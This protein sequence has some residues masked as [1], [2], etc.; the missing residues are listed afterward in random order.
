MCYKL[1]LCNVMGNS[2]FLYTDRPLHSSSTNYKPS[3]IALT[4]K[5]RLLD[6]TEWTH[7]FL[8]VNSLDDNL[9]PAITLHN[10]VQ[11]Y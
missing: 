4:S 6:V 11:E 8:S 10:Y 2:C 3:D 7:V 5:A 1:V 9:L